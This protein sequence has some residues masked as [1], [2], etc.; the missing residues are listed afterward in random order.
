MIVLDNSMR[1]SE[2]AGGYRGF[3]D[4]SIPS[5]RLIPLLYSASDNIM[6]RICRVEWGGKSA[7]MPHSKQ[8]PYSMKYIMI[9]GNLRRELMLMEYK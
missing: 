9:G 8:M 7:K 5:P 1:G 4:Q 6:F 3:G 2:S